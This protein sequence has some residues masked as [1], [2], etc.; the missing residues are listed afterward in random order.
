MRPSAASPRIRRV[1]EAQWHG[2]PRQRLLTFH[3]V[4]GRDRSG[5]TRA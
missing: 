1:L 5:K 2:M 4:S 3:R